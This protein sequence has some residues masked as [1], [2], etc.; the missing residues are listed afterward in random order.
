MAK[1]R[2]EQKERLAP[3]RKYADRVWDLISLFIHID[4]S[5]THEADRQGFRLYNPCP[6]FKF[7]LH[8]GIISLEEQLLSIRSK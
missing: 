5:L 6:G 7:D 8:N 2:G 1:D 3:A 4:A